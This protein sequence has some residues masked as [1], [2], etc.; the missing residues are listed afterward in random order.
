[1]HLGS[2]YLVV[3]DFNKSVDFYENLLEVKVSTKNMERFAQFKFEGHNISIMN[4]YFDNQN[5]EL[6]IHRGQ[7]VEEFDNL[8]AIAEAENTHKFVF[9]FWTEDLEKERERL[10]N[11]NI[12][13]LVTEIKYVN[14]VMPYYYFQVADPDGNVIEVTGSYTPKEGEYKG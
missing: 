5:P 11:I 6:T 12:S 4:G 8:V 14:N 1:M 3:K 7:Y 10:S 13:H 2:V 9:N